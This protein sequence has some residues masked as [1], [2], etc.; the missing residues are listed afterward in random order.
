MLENKPLKGSGTEKTTGWFF[1]FYQQWSGLFGRMNWYD[2]TLIKIQ[3]E[4]SPFTGRFDLDLA[5]LG[6]SINI[7]YVYDDSFNKKMQQEV[8]DIESGKT[9]TVPLDEALRRIRENLSDS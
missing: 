3:G 9:K 4:V 1:S 6:F 2:F 5:L 7:Q 8:A